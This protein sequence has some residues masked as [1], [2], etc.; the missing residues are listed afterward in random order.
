MNG[1]ISVFASAWMNDGPERDAERDLRVQRG[2]VVPEQQLHEHRRAAEEPDVERARARDERVRREA[3]H[4]EQHAEHDADRPSRS[5]SARSSRAARAGCARRTG[6]RRRSPHSK[7]GFVDD[8]ADQRERHDQDDRGGHPAPRAP[9]RDGPDVLGPSGRCGGRLARGH[10]LLHSLNCSARR[11]LA[12]PI[13]PLIVGV[14]DR[15]RLRCPTWRGSSRTCRSAI[16]VLHARRAPA[17]SCRS[18]FGIAM[19]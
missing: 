11:S 3:H 9:D 19:P 4:G 10:R 7:R 1:V 14:A 6:S 2:D 13:A 5:P 8:R 16:S 17:R 15:A 18:S 12:Q